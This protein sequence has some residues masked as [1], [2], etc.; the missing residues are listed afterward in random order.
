MKELISAKTVQEA[1]ANG[2]TEIFYEIK[3]SIVTPEAITVA[4]DLNI[5]LIDKS[6]EENNKLRDIIKQEV[7][8]QNPQSSTTEFQL[9]EIVDKVIAAYKKKTD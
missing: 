9:N 7:I 8:K 6:E 3:S 5:Q 4:K 1:H 2:K